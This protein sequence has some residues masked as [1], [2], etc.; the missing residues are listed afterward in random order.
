MLNQPRVI[1]TPDDPEWD[2]LCAFLQSHAADLDRQDAWPADQLDRCA[3]AGVFQWFAPRELGGQGWDEIDLV[4]GYLRLSAACLTTTFVL[5]QLV[6]ALRRVAAAGNE[7]LHRQTLPRM[8][9]GEHLSTLAISH[10]TTSR[11]HLAEPVLR[12][13]EADGQF[14]LNGYSPWATGAIHAD[15]VVT[16][17]VLPD[18]QQ[19]LI[20]APT[21]L[22]GIE[23]EPPAALQALSASQTGKVSFRDVRLPAANLLGGPAENV[24]RSATGANTG[25]L[26][27]STLAIGLAD[28]C[29]E[30]VEQQAQQRDELTPPAAGLRADHRAIV[31][32][33]LAMARGEPACGPEQLRTRANSLALR[34]SQA[35]LTAAKGA[36]YVWGHPAGRWCR[37]ALFFLVWSCPQP[38]LAANLCEFAGIE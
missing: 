25:G 4:R 11:R 22:P 37:E 2:S 15:S 20:L 28:A 19:I 5:T 26:Q 13:V 34:A 8:L 31:A 9:S 21:D 16:G 6:G 27:T 35:S 10:L 32:D 36:G 17:A 38:V 14:I 18:G 7:N 23:A 1:T 29:I 3:A 30:F 24:M 12:A 33:L